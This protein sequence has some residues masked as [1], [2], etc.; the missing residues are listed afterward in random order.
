MMAAW[1]RPG[2]AGSTWAAPGNGAQSL[3]R[4]LEALL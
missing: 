3:P 1:Y 2:L 4:S